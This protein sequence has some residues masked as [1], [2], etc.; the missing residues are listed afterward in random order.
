LSYVLKFTAQVY[1]I[2][3]Q[4]FL[5][6]LQLLHN[7]RSVRTRLSLLEVLYLTIFM[8]TSHLR[9]FDISSIS[10]N[11]A[12][13]PIPHTEHIVQEHK[14][15]AILSH[16]SVHHKLESSIRFMFPP[17]LIGGL[18]EIIADCLQD[19]RST[20]DPKASHVHDTE[21]RLGKLLRLVQEARTRFEIVAVI[22]RS[23]V[24]SYAF[25]A[26]MTATPAT[27][28]TSCM[29]AGDLALQCERIIQFF[30]LSDH[31]LSQEARL[32]KQLADFETQVQTNP[33]GDIMSAF[34]IPI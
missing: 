1:I 20:L 17:T 24:D 16:T 33:S 5:I 34:G 29:R 9:S 32:A 27:L 25:I 15:M 10:L 13:A 30:S 3:L 6:V 23:S 8:D 7:V 4:R 31:P 2:F 26:H 11:N 12:Q 19:I 22:P 21:T 18:L 28:L 14:F